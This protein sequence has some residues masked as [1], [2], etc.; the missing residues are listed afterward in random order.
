MIKT[1]LA[2]VALITP[3]VVWWFS[4]SQIEK[5]RNARV[6]KKQKQMDDAVASGDSDS[7]SDQLDDL[8]L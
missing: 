3:V 5:R 1:I 2:I 8:G 7:V 6:R 4:P